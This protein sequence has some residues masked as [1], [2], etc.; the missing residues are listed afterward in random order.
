MSR[1]STSRGYKG[2]GRFTLRPLSGGRPFELGNVVEL[3]ESIEVDRTGRQNYQDAAGGELDVEETV[4]S[5][6]F[7]ATVDDI[8]PQNIALAFRGSSVQLPSAS[9][10]DESQ[11]AWVGHRI[12]FRYLP[13]PDETITVAIDASGSWSSS[14]SVAVGDTIVDGTR[15]YLAVVGGDSGVSEPTWPTNL[16]TVTDGDVTWKDLGPIALVLD[17]DFERTPHGLRMLTATADRFHDEL[18][19]P[20]T[21]S[22]TRNPQYLIQALVDAGDQFE[23]V[24]HGLNAVDGGNPITSRYFR[25]KFSPTSG[26]GRHGGDDFSSLALSGTVLADETREGSG[27]SKYLETAM[28]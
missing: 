1:V 15:A 4:T 17:T 24:W 23:I 5:F 14:A 3:S 13:D 28:I 2:R 25:V 19:I 6:T 12:A 27:L 11:S 26:F 16:G 20:L 22:Y 18:P 7:E 10:S 9:I 8:S 21:V